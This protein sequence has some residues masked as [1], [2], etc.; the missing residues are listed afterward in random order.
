MTLKSARR[1]GFQAGRADPC[2]SAAASLQNVASAQTAASACIAQT[3]IEKARG[4]GLEFLKMGFSSVAERAMF[5]T[6]EK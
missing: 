2:R 3:D 1:P 5:T 6:I 4:G